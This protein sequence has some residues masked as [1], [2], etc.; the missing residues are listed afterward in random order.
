ML[1]VS[2]KASE[3][4]KDFLN[5]KTDGPQGIRIMMSEGG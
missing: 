1:Q 2:D 5:K 3:V 4:I